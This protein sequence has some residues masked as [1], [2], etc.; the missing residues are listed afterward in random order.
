VLPELLIAFYTM[1]CL[2]VCMATVGTDGLCPCAFVVFI[3]TRQHTDARYCY[4]NS[5]C[6]S[7]RPSVCPWHAGIVWKRLNISS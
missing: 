1:Y 5:V 4:N 2:C 6:P 3:I 7:V